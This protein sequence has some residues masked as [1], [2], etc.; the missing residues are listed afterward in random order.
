MA[1]LSA[2]GGAFRGRF[3]GCW[4][5]CGACCGLIR[6]LFSQSQGP[7]PR[8]VLADVY[9]GRLMLREHLCSLF[10]DAFPFLGPA[11]GF[12]STFSL[13]RATGEVTW[14]A[15]LL[16]KHHPKQQP[17][18]E[19]IACS[20]RQ[21]LAAEDRARDGGCCRPCPDLL[22]ANRVANDLKRTH[23]PLTNC[24]TDR[25]IS[26]RVAEQVSLADLFFPRWSCRLI[27]A[28][29]KFVNRNVGAFGPRF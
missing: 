6:S 22:L 27:G 10:K 29:N 4:L 18:P 1:G 25:P 24:L 9:S 17:S 26:P 7:K 11:A 28:F 12:R 2:S 13:V 20:N 16:E 15:V 23:W 3:P 19:G 14:P 8:H 21:R 5:R